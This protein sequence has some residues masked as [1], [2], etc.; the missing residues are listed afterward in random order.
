MNCAER[1]VIMGLISAL[2]LL[3]IGLLTGCA[4]RT[5]YVPHGE[6]VRL[7]APVPE[8]PVWV[9]DGEGK[10]V[11]GRVTLHEG[12]YALPDPGEEP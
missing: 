3:I 11:R 9:R 8:H 1:I 10:M 7:A 12:W 6:A 5:I 4:T 2:A